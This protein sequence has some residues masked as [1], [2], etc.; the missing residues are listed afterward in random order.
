MSTP[1][2]TDVDT[3][4]CA[5]RS[6]SAGHW[7]TVAIVL[8]DEVLALRLRDTQACRL[9]AESLEL[10]N[11]LNVEND[12]LR[13]ENETLR[14]AQSA[15]IDQH[16]DEIVREILTAPGHPV[17]TVREVP[18][19]IVTWTGVHWRF[20]VP[21]CRRCDTD[22]HRCPGCGEPLVHGMGV[23]ARCHAAS[24]AYDVEAGRDR[25]SWAA[26]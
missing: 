13:A 1:E 12:D 26:N 19:G 25:E 11:A 4:M 22:T 5:A 17:G 24:D 15:E 14:T 16:Y 7:P 6:G 2:P 8:H 9:L 18:G 10:L 21:N 20:S 3:A 23:C